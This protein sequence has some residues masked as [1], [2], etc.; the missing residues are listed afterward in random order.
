MNKLLTVLLLTAFPVLLKADVY[1]FFAGG[2]FNSRAEYGSGNNAFGYGGGV[3]FNWDQQ[4][5]FMRFALKDGASAGLA[6]ARMQNI[7]KEFNGLTFTVKVKLRGSGRVGF[8]FTDKRS[9]KFVTLTPGWKIHTFILNS[10]PNTRMFMYIR[11]SKGTR[12]DMDDLSVSVAN[13]G[14]RIYPPLGALVVKANST[15]P[16]QT[17]RTMP[18]DLIG[19]FTRFDFETGKKV[20]T[21]AES[22]SGEVTFPAFTA[23]ASGC[24]RII[25]STA[26]EG[27][28]RDVIVASDREADALENAASGVKLK[29][30][31]LRILYLGDSLTDYDRGHNHA[32]I[33]AGMLD[34]FNP[35][36]ISIRNV[37]VGG[38]E[39][40]RIDARLSDSNVYYGCRYHALWEEKYDVIFVACGQNDTV[41]FKESNFSE[42]SIP[43]S[44]VES[45]MRSIVNKIRKK[46]NARIVLVSGVSTPVSNNPSYHFGVP[47]LVEAYNAVIRKVAAELDTEYLDLYTPLKA[48]PEAEKLQLFRNDRVHLSPRGHLFVAT[49]YLKFLARGKDCD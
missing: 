17:F 7:A 26:S 13:N 43:I 2:D 34:K 28:V 32:S 12:F 3:V 1:E 36:A 16:E 38:D 45:R 10:E 33:T 9:E 22:S 15:V 19:K 37:A 46:S 48:L 23:G 27:A 44:E 25:F 8:S 11:Y 4:G 20:V 18:N 24:T 41:T 35:G 42:P 21:P 6:F 5:G 49:E 31:S 40:R 30:K 47:S 39:V 29:G 14:I